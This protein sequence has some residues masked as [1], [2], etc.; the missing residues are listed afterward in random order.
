[1]NMNRFVQR[2][3]PFLLL[4]SVCFSEVYW[5]RYGWQ[6][7]RNVGDARSIA[8]GGIQA[9]HFGTSVSPLYNP[10]TS[11]STGKHSLTYA[12]QSRLAGMIN[13]DLLAFPIPKNGLPINLIILYEGIGD[14]PNTQTL[15]LDFG[16]DGIPGTNDFGEGNGILDEGERLNES[17]LK[18][19][20]QRQVGIHLSTAWQRGGWNFG[21]GLKGLYQSLGKHRA[22]GMGLDA[23]AAIEPWPGGRI[24][25]TITDITTSWLVWENGTV[26]RAGPEIHAGFSQMHRLKIIPLSFTGIV[27]VDIDPSGR[28]LNEDFHFQNVG[29][30]MRVGLNIVYAYKIAV[31]IGRNGI[32]ATTAGL[33]LSWDS[34][35][36]DYAFQVES[37][38]STLGGSHYISLSIDPEWV[39]KWAKRI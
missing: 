25:L 37:S 38:G 16:L 15:L 10:S 12:H 3:I 33:G 36:L 11:G 7:F 4:L 22:M 13:S 18:Y 39:W 30:N 21:L 19:F 35:S 9:T 14:I 2:S 17:E 23:G 31:R 8:L 20:N 5:V 34:M 26:E 32:G 29:A 6:S 27:G 24:G 28:N 1:M